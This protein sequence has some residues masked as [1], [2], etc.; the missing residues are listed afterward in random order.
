MR[1]MGWRGG[2]VVG[3]KIREN[4][5]R[6]LVLEKTACFLLQTKLDFSSTK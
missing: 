6:M 3:F 5:L 1:G 4:L 2:G